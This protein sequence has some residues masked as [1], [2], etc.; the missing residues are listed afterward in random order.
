MPLSAE[1]L[2]LFPPQEAL[3]H[4]LAGGDD[5]ELCFT[6]PRV[7]AAA[8]AA[9]AASTGVPLTRIGTVTD[10]GGLVVRD[11]H[12]VPLARLPRAYAHFG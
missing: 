3:A 11:M 7:A 1:L 4:A 9:I 2:S 5:Y 6:A 12:G 10:G 8:I